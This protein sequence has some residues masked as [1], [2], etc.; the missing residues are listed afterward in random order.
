MMFGKQRFSTK[1][2]DPER[3]PNGST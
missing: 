1:W 3:G 2:R